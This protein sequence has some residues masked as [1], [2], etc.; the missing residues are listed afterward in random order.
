MS[1]QPLAVSI[2]V[3]C[4]PW[5]VAQVRLTGLPSPTVFRCMASLIQNVR[6]KNT[7]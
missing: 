6:K 4:M 7:S 1:I 5:Q 2:P 3:M